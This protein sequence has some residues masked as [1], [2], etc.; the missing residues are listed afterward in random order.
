M[1]E[2]FLAALLA[3]LLVLWALG[4]LIGAI[5]RAVKSDLL[6]VV[7][8]IFIPGYGFVLTIIAIINSIF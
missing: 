5:I 4:S 3:P 2:T 7:L 6:S 1:R 8:S